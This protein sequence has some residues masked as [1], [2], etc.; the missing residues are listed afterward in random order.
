LALIDKVIGTW[1][2][3]GKAFSDINPFTSYI[4]DKNFFL[5]RKELHLWKEGIR[6]FEED[7]YHLKGILQQEEES[8]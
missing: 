8:I 1:I 2:L 6:L 5:M 4:N 7:C 3:T